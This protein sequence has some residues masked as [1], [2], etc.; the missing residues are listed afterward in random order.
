MDIRRLTDDYAVSPQIAA[1][2]A[3]ALREAG[4]STVICNRPD[5]EVPPGMQADAIRAAVEAAGLKFVDNPIT[6]GAMGPGE[7]E[8]QRRTIAEAEGPVLAY[9]ASGTR[10]T[11]VWMLGAAPE[12]A[13]DALLS[14]AREHGY[15]LDMLRPQLDALHKG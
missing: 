11:V 14:A 9:C 1:A 7:V 12:T 2:D 5:D 4:F 10:S 13:P 6:H 3:E 8:A 15:Q